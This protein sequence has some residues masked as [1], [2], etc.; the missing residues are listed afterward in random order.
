M[1]KPQLNAAHLNK[2]ELCAPGERGNA[3]FLCL[4]PW[5]L[6]TLAQWE[7]SDSLTLDH[8]SLLLASVVPDGS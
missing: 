7:R 3:V 5:K 1:H 6:G 4:E 8:S 2:P